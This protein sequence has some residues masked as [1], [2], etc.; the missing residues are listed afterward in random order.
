MFFLSLLVSLSLS[1]SLFLSLSLSPSLF[2]FFS[3]SLSL[4]LAI[5]LYLMLSQ[6]W[7]WFYLSLSFSLSLSVYLSLSLSIECIALLSVNG[8][9]TWAEGDK[10]LIL[11]NRIISTMLNIIRFNIAEGIVDEVYLYFVECALANLLLR[12]IDPFVHC[13]LKIKLFLKKKNIY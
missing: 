13:Y 5:S 6:H 2:L 1:W 3:L 11:G 9:V 12:L 8:L 7:M 4:S 10:K